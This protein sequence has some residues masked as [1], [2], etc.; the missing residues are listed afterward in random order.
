VVKPPIA[1]EGFSL[2]MI[3]HERTHQHAGHR[4]IRDALADWL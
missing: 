4:W 1:V 3:W 2:S